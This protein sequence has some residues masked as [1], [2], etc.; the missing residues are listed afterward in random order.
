MD[1]GA[2]LIIC[3]LAAA[4]V[5]LACRVL[6]MRATAR[7][8]GRAFRSAVQEGS[9]VPVTVSTSDK[10]MRELAIQLNVQ[11][12]DFR[13][14]RHM[15]EAGDRRVKEGISNV[16]H[17][18]RTPLTAIVGY[19]ELLENETDA[20]TASRY[21]R[22]IRERAQAMRSLTGELF[23]WALAAQPDRK[24]QLVPV[25][26]QDALAE[27]IA[28]SYP[29][30]NEK[31]VRPILQFPDTAVVRSADRKSL[32]RI[33]GNLMTNAIQH[34]EGDLT[35]TL[36]PSGR[37]DF[38]NAAPGMDPLDVERLFGRFYTV[39]G[40][41]GSTGLGL[42]IARMLSEQM[43]GS[44]EASLE[45]GVLTVSVLFPDIPPGTPRPRVDRAELRDALE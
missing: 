23:D 15:F 34:G 11:L 36:H 6:A 4:T 44:M 27:S 18:L 19:L 1:I 20:E 5:Y 24:E 40:G 21:V 45:N 14:K 8:I 2:V 31:G 7:E 3:S 17:D 41:S 28:V 29:A 30:F 32:A 10:A 16:A 43:N 25:R 9:N 33:F 37:V 12:D 13:R 35:I 22:I 26:L 39:R 38:S 42:S